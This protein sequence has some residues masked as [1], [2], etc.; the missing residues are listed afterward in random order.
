MGLNIIVKRRAVDFLSASL[1]EADLGNQTALHD[2]LNRSVLLIGMMFGGL[3]GSTCLMD[4]FGRDQTCAMLF[5]LAS[6]NTFLS[7]DAAQQSAAAIVANTAKGMLFSQ[8]GKPAFKEI[9]GYGSGE[10]LIPLLTAIINQVQETEKPRLLSVAD[11]MVL[12]CIS[13]GLSD[14]Y[15]GPK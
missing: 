12:H 5:A 2:F 13:P 8:S 14:Q 11:M 9:V 15:G 6:G 7:S 3:L 1:I 4:S 10:Y